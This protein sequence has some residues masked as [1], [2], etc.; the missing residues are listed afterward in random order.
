MNPNPSRRRPALI[1]DAQQRQSLLT[2]RVLGQA[3]VEV[4]VAETHD[5]VAAFASRWC[6]RRVTLPDFGED[7]EAFVVQV[8]RLC[9]SVGSPIIIASHDGAIEA[10]RSRRSDV[11]RVGT[12]ALA[13][14][15]AL[16]RAVDKQATLAIAKRLGI[17]VPPGGS[18]KDMSTARELVRHVGLPAVIKP[19]FSWLTDGARGG[20]RGQ[21]SVARSEA[22]AL[23]Q[24]KRLVDNGIVALV[25][26]WLPGSRDAIGI[27]LSG[28]ELSAMFAVRSH[29]MSP[30]I[31]GSSIIRETI[32][33]PTDIASSAEALVRELSLEGYAEVEF[34]RDADGR[35]LLMEVNPR[36]NAGV[37]VAVRAGVNV[38]LLL[39][40]WAAGEPLQ[41]SLRYRPGQRMRWLQGDARWLEEALWTPEHPESPGR[42]AA[43]ATFVSEFARPASYD[44]WDRTDVRPTLFEARLVARMVA[45]RVRGRLRKRRAHHTSSSADI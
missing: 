41:R 22:A 34:R 42:L 14:E 27:F 31:G 18:V 10:L 37:E 24:I 36:L 43:I 1:L 23:A 16:S 6:S 29:R 20:E 8:M 21:P 33:L 12:L 15:H 30:M 4:V 7:P 11:E 39:Y 25:Q 35:P 45:E 28:G 26:R 19:A 2:L 38:P 5:R 32:P 40:Q 3:G 9:E 17:G 13:P 44:Y